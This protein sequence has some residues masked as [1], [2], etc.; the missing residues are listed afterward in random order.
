MKIILI[1]HLLYPEKYD[2]KFQHTHAHTAGV[3]PGEGEAGGG[4][5]VTWKPN[6]ATKTHTGTSQMGLVNSGEVGGHKV[7]G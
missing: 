7:P 2:L 6:S 1:H 5:G 4:K 3:I